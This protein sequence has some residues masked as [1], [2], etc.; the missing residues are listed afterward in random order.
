MVIS[1]AAYVGLLARGAPNM[2]DVGTGLYSAFA[3]GLCA[4]HCRGSGNWIAGGV[5]VR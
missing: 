3:V 1:V 4:E 2:G 5:A